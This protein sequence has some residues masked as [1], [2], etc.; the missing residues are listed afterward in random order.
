MSFTSGHIHSM[1]LDC[2]LRYQVYNVS[3]YVTAHPGQ[4]AILRNVGG[5]STEGF[6]KQTAHR[7]VKKHIASL[8][9][10]FYVGRLSPV[11]GGH[12]EAT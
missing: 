10:K 8:L 6:K 11:E 7:V 12:I 4:E 3:S 5:D 9:E 1:N 2:I